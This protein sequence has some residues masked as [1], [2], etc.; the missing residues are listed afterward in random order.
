LKGT[1]LNYYRLTDDIH[2][3]DHRRLGDILDGEKV[4]DADLF[5]TTKTY[6]DSNRLSVQADD[7]PDFDF[8]LAAFDVPIVSAKLARLLQQSTSEEVQLIPVTIGGKAGY[9]I[10]NTLR[11][12]PCLDESQSVYTKW[13]ESDGRPDRI[14]QYRMVSELVV[15]SIEALG[16]D[17]LRI[18]GWDVPLV[19]SDNIVEEMKSSGVRG[20]ILEPLI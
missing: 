10:L 8:S 5:T 14:G 3:D 6:T 9:F 7:G 4:V 17:V 1:K 19:V 2:A 20:V 15:D 16:I 12:V 18:E 11:K 13:Q